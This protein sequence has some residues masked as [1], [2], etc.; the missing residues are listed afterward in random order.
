MNVN[1]CCYGFVYK[2]PLCATVSFH[3]LLSLL[4]LE[5][6]LPF[7]LSSYFIFLDKPGVT[8]FKLL[9]NC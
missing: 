8:L 4:L 6:I 5:S 1:L 2:I 7:F 3:L 9:L